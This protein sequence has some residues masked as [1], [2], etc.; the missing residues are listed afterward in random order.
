MRDK[1]AA[2]LQTLHYP[3]E[4]EAILRRI[5]YAARTAIEESGTKMLHLIFGFVEWFESD[6]SD[7]PH[8]APIL[9]VPVGIEKGKT[10]PL[11]GTF[12]Y[13]IAYSSADHIEENLSLREKLK[14]DF[15]LDMPELSDQEGAESYFLKFRSIIAAK[16]RWRIRRRITLG[17]ASFGKFLMFRDLDPTSWPTE[18]D[19]VGHPLISDFFEGSKSAESAIA[20]EYLIDAWEP[21]EKVPD[22][23]HDADSSQHSALIDALE[24]KNLVIEGPPGTGKSQT[25]TN[26]IA[27]ALADGKTVL[28]VSEKLAALEVVRRRLD[29]AGLGIFCLELHSHKMEKR[30]LLSELEERLEA[31][32]SFKAPKDLA[33]KRTLLIRARQQLTDYVELINK[34]FS[35]LGLSGFDVI[36][37]RERSRQMLAFDPA[38]VEHFVVKRDHNTGLADFQ[39]DCDVLDVYGR[40]LNELR[41][42][43]PDLE[44]HPW[45]QVT[46]ASLDYQGELELC[47]NLDKIEKGAQEIQNALKDLA[48]VTGANLDAVASPERVTD[49]SANTFQISD[50][51]DPASRAFLTIA[52]N[53]ARE[54]ELLS[55]LHDIASWKKSR[56]ELFQKLPNIAL[57][58]DPSTVQPLR[59]ACQRAVDFGLGNFSLSSLAILANESESLRSILKPTSILS[60]DSLTVQLITCESA[61]I[62]SQVFSSAYRQTKRTFAASFASR[63][64]PRKKEMIGDLRRAV[65]LLSKLKADAEFLAHHRTSLSYEDLGTL[66]DTAQS[67]VLFSERFGLDKDQS[68]KTTQAGMLEFVNNCELA[69]HI[70]GNPFREYVGANFQGVDTSLLV[71]SDALNAL[72]SIHRVDIPEDVKSWLLQAETAD[73]LSVLRTH[74]AKISAQIGDLNVALAR[75]SEL[76]DINSQEWWGPGPLTFSTLERIAEKALKN[77]DALSGWLELGRAGREVESASLTQLSALA[78]TGAISTA[79]LVPAYTYVF[80][81]TLAQQLTSDRPHLLQFAGLK[82]EAARERF[83]QLDKELINLNRQSAAVRIDFRMV[84]NGVQSG[85]VGQ[86]T[87]LG[88]IR[89]RSE[90]RGDTFLS[91]SW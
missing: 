33:E 89:R 60:L 68:L 47:R 53:P 65:D 17:L 90:K 28:F 37:L 25:I 83:V 15:G 11:S 84:P 6:A 59:D 22:L 19:L 12:T 8:L 18:T 78:D 64:R 5:S 81:N 48:S 13:E 35:A 38:L 86:L 7:Q 55:L 87:E 10:D 4:L 27:A 45:R 88:L 42:R 58:R 44:G 50:P 1:R 32:G 69:S 79:D 82:Q 39:S 62:F 49:L 23:I 76:G 72:N 61:T 77:Q 30:R 41:R 46:N 40:H 56:S 20:E 57:S 70:A 16:P 66:I 9:L 29:Q 21:Q 74:I 63:N 71:I 73:R 52:A 80:Y 91:D 34:P 14:R 31:R 43:F 2:Q 26:L 67:V 54:A 36:W 3:N 85:P 24:G 51:E 75:F